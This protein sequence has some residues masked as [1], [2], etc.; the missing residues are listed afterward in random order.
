[1]SSETVPE[2]DLLD[3][4]PD[5][6]MIARQLCMDRT[7]D[8]AE[9]IAVIDEIPELRA[10]LLKRA[11][12]PFFRPKQPVRDLPRAVSLLGRQEVLHVLE[13]ITP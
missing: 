8:L 7:S 9:L 10:R 2:P 11:N 5:P 1:M 12:S 6:V 13:S 3:A 4:S